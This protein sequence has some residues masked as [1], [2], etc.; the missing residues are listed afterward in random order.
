VYW[1]WDIEES[2]RDIKS[3]RYG[4]SL[5]YTGTRDTD[6]LTVLLL[7]AQIAYTVLFIL[8]TA[9]DKQGIQYQLQANSVKNRR[10]LSIIYLASLTLRLKNKI[11]L[12]DDGIDLA[13]AQ[14]INVIHLHEYLKY[15]WGYLRCQVIFDNS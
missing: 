6:R 15:L 4:L 1:G 12:D 3:H 10:V 7:I 5:R 2:F 11:L 13:L 8:G 14:I 9:L